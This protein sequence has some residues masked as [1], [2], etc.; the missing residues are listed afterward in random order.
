M[1][2]AST[3]N[4]VLVNQKFYKAQKCISTGNIEQAILILNN[5]LNL[6]PEALTELTKLD[7]DRAKKYNEIDG[8]KTAIDNRDNFTEGISN[9]DSFRNALYNIEQELNQRI[10]LGIKKKDLSTAYEYAK[11][12][13]YLNNSVPYNIKRY[14]EV[15]LAYAL[16]IKT[17]NV[18]KT[19]TLL[20]ELFV[21]GG[22]YDNSIIDKVAEEMYNLAKIFYSGLYDYTHCN[23]LCKLLFTKDERSV[24]LYLDNCVQHITQLEMNKPELTLF[25]KQ[26]NQFSDVNKATAY[27]AQILHKSETAKLEYVDYILQLSDSYAQNKEFD[28]SIDI[29]NDA[30][31]TVYDKRLI[32]R[33]IDIIK[34]FP[35]IK[36]Y[37]KITLLMPLIGKHEDAEPMLAQSYLELCRLEKSTDKKRKWLEKSFAFKAKHS[38]FFNVELYKDTFQNTLTEL[39]SLAQ[40]YSDIGYY[41]DAYDILSMLYSHYSSPEPLK[42]YCEL[43]V[44]ES[45]NCSSYAKKISLLESAVESSNRISEEY[46]PVDYTPEEVLLEILLNAKKQIKTIESPVEKNN[47]LKKAYLFV[48]KYMNDSADPDFLKQ[49]NETK[50]IIVQFLVEE[51]RQLEKENRMDEALQIYKSIKKQ[52]GFYFDAETRYFICLLKTTDD[53]SKNDHAR[54]KSL[55]KEKSDANVRDL[56]YRYSL[57][58]LKKGD[59]QNEAGLIIDRHLPQTHASAGIRNYCN[60]EF[61]KGALVELDRFNRDLSLMNTGYLSLDDAQKLFNSLNNL[62][63]NVA[64]KL[65][66]LKGKFDDQKGTIKNYILKKLFES[67]EYTK[68]LDIIVDNETE[69][70]ENNLLLHNAAVAVYGI[71]QSGSLNSSNYKKIISTWITAVYQDILFIDSLHY[72]SWDKQYMF[73]LAESLG[74]I[75]DNNNLPENVNYNDPIDGTVSIGEV[76][77]NLLTDFKHLLTDTSLYSDSQTMEFERFYEQEIEAVTDLF[78]LKMENSSFNAT[79]YFSTSHKPISAGIEKSLENELESTD[80]DIE[81]ALEVGLKYGF[82]TK[83]YKD[84]QSAKSICNKLIHSAEKLNQPEVSKNFTRNNVSQTKEYPKLYHQLILKIRSIL[85]RQIKTEIEFDKIYKTYLFICKAIDDNTLSFILSNYSNKY[86][87]ARLNDENSGYKKSQGLN[88]LFN[89][90]SL[91]ENNNQLN[92]NI[93]LVI[94]AAIRDI[95]SGEDP[96]LLKIIFESPYFKRF[97]ENIIQEIDNHL[98][99]LMLIGN[100]EKIES[101]IGKLQ[102]KVSPTNRDKVNLIKQKKNDLFIDIELSQIIDKV[103]AGRLSHPDALSQM[104]TLYE[105]YPEH[106]RLCDN[107]VTMCEILI[108]DE[109]I[110][111]GLRSDRVKYLLDLF[112]ANRSATLKSSANKLVAKYNSIINQLDR[113]NK[114]LMIDSSNYYMGTSLNEKGLALKEGLN[115][116]KKMSQ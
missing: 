107:I 35:R 70:H 55:V 7:F 38:K 59:R 116:Y 110:G 9:G 113:T 54:I 66:D 77:K 62:E 45:R 50:E 28:K 91:I 25:F 103:N 112:I 16:S 11:L 29:I 30:L 97:E 105:K 2:L 63:E 48:E 95:V 44:M 86:V 12:L 99:S 108:D 27:Y 79:P 94:N 10:S 51:G 34:K 42:K 71:V 36:I 68:A 39:L 18:Y 104:Q 22:K 21:S 85:D 47:V 24:G 46:L 87:I 72:T 101:L 57:Y 84:F 111:C 67:E 96:S 109:I 106:Q 90:F 78:A 98:Q 100:S 4:K 83:K 65:P 53:I 114:V 115:Y 58:L 3:I 49:L 14:E 32:D 69:I 43:K 1:G 60:N 33:K 56:A 64:G 41:D 8:F 81:A 93:L 89:M 52:Y 37:Y 26:L 17:S 20:S 82:Q 88:I 19:K 76:Q 73:T 6:H 15:K 13:V 40:E 92:N 23:D 31:E 5:I 102:L 80:I 75:N 61:V 74:R